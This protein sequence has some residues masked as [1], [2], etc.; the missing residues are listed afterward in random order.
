MVRICIKTGSPQQA[1]ILSALF[2]SIFPLGMEIRDDRLWVYADD[3]ALQDP[4]NISYIAA[5][6]EQ[7]NFD[8]T[9]EQVPDVNWN[10]E[11]E[12]NFNPVV[13]EDILTIRAVFHD[14][15]FDTAW[16]VTIQPKMSFGTGHH[17]T[18]WMMV[19]AMSLLDL[20]GR[21]ILDAGTGT[22]ILAILA[23]MWRASSVTGFDHDSWSY[24]NAL[25]NVALNQKNK[26]H[27]HINLL[28]GTLS[29]IT[30]ADFD[31]ILANINRN[32]LLDRAEELVARL[33]AGGYLV[34][35]GFYDVDS[36]GL[37]ERFHP[38]NL[39]AQYLLTRESWACIVL[40]KPVLA[41]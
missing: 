31:I 19:K 21:K 14:E 13:V 23:S 6:K 38:L 18:T 5:W 9:T 32:F 25:E 33:A 2:A 8:L 17:A 35:S 1:E 11:W 16:T 7:F 20:A 29:D 12:S 27:G 30:A 40:R 28:N 26:L 34:I 10:R 37:L 4:E 15:R 24:E 22:G 41:P 36:K 3:L 39:V